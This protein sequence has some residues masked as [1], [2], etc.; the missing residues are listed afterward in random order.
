[1]MKRRKPGRPPKDDQIV[2]DVRFAAAC[3][4][5]LILVEMEEPRLGNYEQNE[6]EQQK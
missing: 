1:M 6:S 2:V 4:R 5:R 3:A